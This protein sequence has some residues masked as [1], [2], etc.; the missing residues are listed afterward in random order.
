MTLTPFPNFDPLDG[1]DL[2]VTLSSDNPVRNR[3]HDPRTG[4]R[5][6]ETERRGVGAFHDGGVTR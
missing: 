5:Q 2:R 6:R 4:N 3:I 1:T